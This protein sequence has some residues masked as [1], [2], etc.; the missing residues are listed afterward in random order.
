ML[1]KSNV[2]PCVL[3][4]RKWLWLWAS[5]T[6]YSLLSNGKPF[7]SRLSLQAEGI[8]VLGWQKPIPLA[9]IYNWPG[10]PP[11]C[12]KSSPRSPLH[13][14]SDQPSQVPYGTCQTLLLWPMLGNVCPPGISTS[15]GHQ[16]HSHCVPQCWQCVSTMAGHFC[17]CHSLPPRLPSLLTSPA[18]LSSG[19]PGPVASAISFQELLER[20]TQN[21][22][23]SG[24]LWKHGKNE[25][26]FI[27]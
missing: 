3:L 16:C 14:L 18:R 2:I 7:K 21:L 26:H 5:N 23:L 10:H 27:S 8:T 17:C 1:L 13:V 11:G 19:P 4:F 20:N 25:P 6:V 9:L 12:A 24:G 22:K 15:P